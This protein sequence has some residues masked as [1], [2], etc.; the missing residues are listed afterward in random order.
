MARPPEPFELPYGPRA[1]FAHLRALPCWPGLEGWGF[2]AVEVEGQGDPPVAW[3]ELEL[4]A[5][6]SLSGYEVV[7]TG[8][9]R[10][11]IDAATGAPADSA[12]ADK[13]LREFAS[14]LEEALHKAEQ[15]PKAATFLSGHE[16]L[17]ASYQDTG[18]RVRLVYRAGDEI[19]VWPDDLC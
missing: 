6:E 4:T 15:D 19:L 16:M 8:R 5:P 12:E 3:A 1:V 11:E 2:R 14:G 13:S 18:G 17:R 7:Y 9:V 10:L